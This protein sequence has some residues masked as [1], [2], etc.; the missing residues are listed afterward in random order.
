MIDPANIHIFA[1]IRVLSVEMI[2]TGR[3]A[4]VRL[5]QADGQET[6]VL[7]PIAVAD[8]LQRQLHAALGKGSA[9]G[10]LAT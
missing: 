4:A 3:T 1:A 2:D 10:E 6:V 8:D 7:L 5:Q 9:A